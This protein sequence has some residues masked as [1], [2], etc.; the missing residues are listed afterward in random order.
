[1]PKER[2]HSSSLFEL[3][4]CHPVNRGGKHYS[5]RGPAEQKPPLIFTNMQNTLS[6]MGGAHKNLLAAATLL[7]VSALIY[8]KGPKMKP[9]ELVRRHLETLGAQEVRATTKGRSAEGNGQME[10]ISGG[11]G[12]LFGPTT[13]L[14]QG[15]KVFLRMQFDQASYPEERISFDSDEVSISEISSGQR[16]LLGEFLHD[17]QRVIKEGLLGGVLS[18]AWPLLDL[19]ARRPKLKYK[20]LKNVNG[21]QLLELEYK[22]RKGWGPVK[23]RLYFDPKSFRHIASIYSVRSQPA[24]NLGFGQPSGTPTRIRFRLE[25]WFSDFQT[26]DGLNLPN[27]WKIRVIMEINERDY[28]ED[29]GM[30]YSQITHNSNIDPQRFAPPQ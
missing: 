15:E 29:W 2:T 27:D 25:E 30:L 3:P 16:S 18:T 1:M 10:V 17:H 5:R 13:F 26:H 21:Q 4:S 22:P 24:G 23:G 6:V 8:A 14:S 12:Y 28:Q 20:G 11:S 19:K 9:E 7:A